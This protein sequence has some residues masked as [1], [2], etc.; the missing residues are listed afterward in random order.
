MH[1]DIFIR[2]AILN[3]VKF[4][5][6]VLVLTKLSNINQ[7]MMLIMLPSRSFILQMLV[8]SISK[9]MPTPWSNALSQLMG[10]S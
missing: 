3:M 10:K 9:K 5:F 8:E 7:L 2:E 4:M 1:S 6:L